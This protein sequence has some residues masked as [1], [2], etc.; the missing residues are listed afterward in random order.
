MRSPRFAIPRS[1]FS[2]AVLLLSA[3]Q[4]PEGATSGDTSGDTSDT[5]A[6][7]PDQIFA[8]ACAKILACDCGDAQADEAKCVADYTDGF[9][10]DAAVYVAA[11][12]TIDLTCI[13]Q[14]LEI[15]R[16]GCG[17]A[18]LLEEGPPDIILACPVCQDAHGQRGLGEPCTAQ[19]P[20]I[21]SDCAQGLACSFAT[22]APPT[23]YDPCAAPVVDAP[24]PANGCGDT[25]F[26]DRSGACIPRVGRRGDECA[27]EKV[28]CGPGLA[29]DFSGDEDSVCA[30]GLD[31]G[32]P[33]E[34]CHSCC[35]GEYECEFNVPA[36]TCVPFA[37]IG[38]SCE[39]GRTCSLGAYCS[40]DGIC[41]AIPGLGESCEDY[42]GNEAICATATSTCVALPQ[43]GEPCVDSSCV[44]WT[45]CGA[46]DICEPLPPAVC[47]Y[48]GD[49]TGSATTL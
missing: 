11:G 3:C 6:G 38:E 37:A 49:T 46:D 20:G 5:T 30:P 36:R 45:Q 41:A 7:E 17:P 42:C 14:N 18:P 16:F 33:C 24:C 12:L 44:Q 19:D 47:G 29:C 23:C 4:E 32:E 8:E 34:E 26:C 21:A 39:S 10:A 22:N 13:A 15:N 1:I 28:V 43:P 27:N 2:V 40:A 25:M 35:I 48:T 9:N 31:P